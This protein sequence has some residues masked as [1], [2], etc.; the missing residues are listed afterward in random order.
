MQFLAQISW[1]LFEHICVRPDNCIVLRIDKIVSNLEP[2]YF[3]FS[4][5]LL[6]IFLS[7]L[8][9]V[10]HARQIYCPPFLFRLSLIPCTPASNLFAHLFDFIDVQ[11][12]IHLSLLFNEGEYSLLIF[13]FMNTQ[14]IKVTYPDHGCWQMSD[15]WFDQ[16]VFMAVID[17]KYFEEETFQN[18]MEHSKDIIVVK[19]WDVF[20]VVATH[21]GCKHCQYKVPMR[22]QLLPKK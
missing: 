7:D 9:D 11:I 21:S 16:H 6:L 17:L 19:P 5:V 18:I 10:E 3:F 8:I 2:I 13:L 22:K 12:I 4:S 20:G 14:K 1:H 15:E